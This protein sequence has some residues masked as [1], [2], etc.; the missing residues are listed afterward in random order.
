MTCLG[1]KGGIGTASRLLPSGHTLGALVLTNFGEHERLTVG[2]RPGRG[3]AAT[4]R[5]RAGSA[6]PARA[7]SSS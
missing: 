7:S 1:W 3:G 6:T 4:G 2:R 5:R